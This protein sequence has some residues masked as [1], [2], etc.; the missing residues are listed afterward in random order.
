MRLAEKKDTRKYYN[1]VIDLGDRYAYLPPFEIHFFG[2]EKAKMSMQEIQRADNIKQFPIDNVNI[3]FLKV[4]YDRFIRYQNNYINYPAKW[5]KIVRNFCKTMPTLH[6]SPELI[7]K[8]F[9][10][11]NVFDNAPMNRASVNIYE[12]IYYAAPNCIQI[13]DGKWYLRGDEAKALLFDTIVALQF[14]TKNYKENLNFTLDGILVPDNPDLPD[15][16]TLPHSYKIKI[17]LDTLDLTNGKLPITIT[18][19]PKLLEGKK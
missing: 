14:I 12:M 16:D 9:T 5:P 1:K 18:R 6:T 10:Y 7:M 4:L 11:L 13:K 15:F 2:K 19:N 8:A 3:R 17:I